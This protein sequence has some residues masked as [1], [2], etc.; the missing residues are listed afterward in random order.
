VSSSGSDPRAFAAEVIADPIDAGALRALGLSLVA[1]GDRGNGAQAL[2]LSARAAGE[3]GQLA[4]AIAVAKEL[5]AIDGGAAGKIIS[6]LAAAYGHES[7][8]VDPAHRARPPSVSKPKP[9]SAAGDPVKAIAAARD[10]LAKQKPGPLPKVPLFHALQPA[11]FS[12]LCALATLREHDAESVVLDVGSKGEAFYLIAR[13]TVRITRPQSHG[14]E[15]LL[16]HLRAGSFFGEMALLT[17]SPR[18]AKATTESRALLLEIPRRGLDELAAASP[19]FSSVLAAYARDRLLHNLML[20]SGVFAP[21][22]EDARSRLIACFQPQ[23]FEVGKPLLVEG[24]PGGSLFV[25]VAGSVDIEKK[26]GAETLLV[27]R[28]GPG[29]VV[30]EISLLTKRP[31]TATVRATKHVN[32]LSLPRDAFNQIVGDFPGVLAHLYQLAVTRERDLE[33]FLSDAVQEADD[34]LI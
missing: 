10:A 4:L 30:G 11:P 9:A 24:E 25:I 7:K 12:R 16:S 1:A 28:L 22:D 31:V 29:D 20:T 33:R 18:T 23:S 2:G 8:R 32:A 15:I 14:D 21:L 5:E 26:D 13:G 27:T 19:E 34:Y 17:E 3:A 6:G